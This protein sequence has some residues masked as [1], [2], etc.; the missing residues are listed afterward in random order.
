MQ[1]PGYE[2]EKSFSTNSC[3]RPKESI[4]AALPVARSV[5]INRTV[6]ARKRIFSIRTT[7]EPFVQE[8][9]YDA[10]NGA[11]IRLLLVALSYWIVTLPDA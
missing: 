8:N 7:G 2:V 1:R 11:C 3:A 5:L 9:E 4:L 6:S 10:G